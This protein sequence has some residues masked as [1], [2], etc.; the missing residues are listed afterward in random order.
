MNEHQARAGAQGSAFES[1]V[2]EA[3]TRG[4]WE[5]VARRARVTELELEVD[6]IA[7]DPGGVEWWI[8]CKGSWESSRNGAQRSDTTKKAIGTAAL[9]S[10]CEYRRPYLLITSDL[11]VAGSVADR[12]LE[13]AV[14]EGWFDKV[15]EL[16][17]AAIGALS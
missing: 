4:G 5:I 14:R 10:S 17:I 1:H 2:E 16:P 3:L 9:L 13:R 7:V 11:P 12:S 15:V 8:E 6:F